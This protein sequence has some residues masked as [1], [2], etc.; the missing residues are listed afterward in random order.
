[1]QALSLEFLTFTGLGKENLL[2]FKHFASGSFGLQPSNIRHHANRSQQKLSD[3]PRLK[4][5]WQD[6]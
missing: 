3:L 4:G 6:A 2:Q 1:M 5:A